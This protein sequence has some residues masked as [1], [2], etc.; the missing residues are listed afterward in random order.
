MARSTCAAFAVVLLSFA[1]SHA[2]EVSTKQ[3]GANP[4]LTWKLE[5]ARDF[6]TIEKAWVR[7]LGFSQPG[8]AAGAIGIVVG[9]GRLYLAGPGHVQCR[10]AMAGKIVWQKRDERFSIHE[11][12]WH[13]FWGVNPQPDKKVRDIDRT[14]M[15]SALGRNESISGGK[16]LLVTAMARMRNTGM[17]YDAA[18]KKLVHRGEAPIVL[19]PVKAR[20]TLHRR[21]GAKVYLLDHDGRRTR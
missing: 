10:D 18:R 3:Y 7:P 15:V 14:Q 21:G 5:G 17:R 6:E 4:H 9:E 2:G 8:I 11:S 20:I 19:E 1:A 13:H 16:R 12:N